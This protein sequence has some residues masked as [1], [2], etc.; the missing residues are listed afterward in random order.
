MAFHIFLVGL[1][2]ALLVSIVVESGFLS[3]RLGDCPNDV[4][5]AC[6]PGRSA[7]SECH[8][9]WARWSYPASYHAGAA[10]QPEN[11]RT[12]PAAK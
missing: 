8:T 9:G 11:T 5:P 3:K 7:P 10:R 4:P 12:V 6:R 2:Q 1:F